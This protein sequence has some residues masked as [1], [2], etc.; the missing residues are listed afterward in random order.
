MTLLTNVKTAI[1]RDASD[2]VRLFR[3]TKY[4]WD[5]WASHI[6]GRFSRRRLQ[7]TGLWLNIASGGHRVPGW[8]NVDGVPAADVRIDLRRRWPMLDGCA[9]YIYCEHFLDHLEFPHG[10]EK[11]LRECL[12]VLEP[13]GRIRLVVHDLELI[14]RAYL[15]KDQRFFQESGF[16]APT[17]AESV[18]QV[19]RFNDF[20][21]FMY[22]FDCLT[23]LLLAVG[24]TRVT[25]SAFRSSEVPE[26]NIDIDVPDR[27]VQSLYV[28]ATKPE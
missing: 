16:E 18:N 27:P 8:L 19:A 24:F 5:A 2:M 13:G 14:A 4:E 7:A 17:F 10:A 9:E 11:F 12:R 26:L 25:R 6:A 15:A 28:E 20:H 3:V 22:D 23:R 21:R 1:R